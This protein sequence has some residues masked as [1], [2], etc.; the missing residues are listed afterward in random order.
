[1]L[2]L[3]DEP[4]LLPL[5]LLVKVNTDVQKFFVTQLLRALHHDSQGDVDFRRHDEQRV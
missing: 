5:V 2:D 4:G 3:R 1:M